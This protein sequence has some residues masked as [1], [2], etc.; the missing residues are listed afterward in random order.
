MAYLVRL[1]QT[2]SNEVKHYNPDMD[3]E[4]AAALIEDH[5]LNKLN[6][7]KIISLEAFFYCRELEMLQ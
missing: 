5:S 7:I 1:L 2:G 3:A 4:L 6:R